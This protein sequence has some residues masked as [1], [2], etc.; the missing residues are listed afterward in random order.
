[1]DPLE[2]T[3]GAED[4]DIIRLKPRED[5]YDSNRDTRYQFGPFYIIQLNKKTIPQG[6]INMIVGA[7]P[8]QIH[9]RQYAHRIS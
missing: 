7:G 4:A 1:M 2:R 9:I 6:R 5:Q 8:L 3:F